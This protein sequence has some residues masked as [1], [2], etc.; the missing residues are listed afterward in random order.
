MIE[1]Y[2]N[3]KEF[4]R[5]LKEY[6]IKLS[7][8]D[9]LIHED[10]D[11]DNL[12]LTEVDYLSNTKFDVRFGKDYYFDEF[13]EHLDRQ[14]KSRLSE[15]N[16]KLKEYT[17]CPSAIIEKEEKGRLTWGKV[18][19]K[20]ASFFASFISL[21]DDSSSEEEDFIEWLHKEHKIFLRKRYHKIKRLKNQF[22]NE[23]NRYKLQIDI[24][25]S[26]RRMLRRFSYS[27][28]DE[29]SIRSLNIQKS[30]ERLCSVIKLRSFDI[31]C[32]EKGRYN[33]YS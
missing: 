21:G 12:F 10:I 33:F 22:L 7:E 16:E 3:S 25:S 18:L 5:G 29:E 26:I 15:F 23:R 30:V 28:I 20:V 24:R 19:Q 32:N 4:N 9:Y 11:F 17:S 6:E 31:F 1:T 2:L 27:S 13:L 8:L 14:S